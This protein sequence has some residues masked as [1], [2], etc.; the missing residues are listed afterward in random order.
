MKAL[1]LAA[2]RG[3]RISRYLAGNPKCTVDLG[4]TSLIEYTVNMLQKNGIHNI[5]IA[6]GYRQQ[7]IRQKLSN[8]KVLYYYNP[9]FDVTN[10]ITSAWFAKDFLSADDDLIIMNGDVFLE[11]S[12]LTEMLKCKK[13]PVLFSD[14]TR[15]DEADYKLLYRNGILEGYGKELKGNEITGEYVGVAIIRMNFIP[16]FL[17]KMNEM[18]DNQQHSVWWENVLYDNSKKID[19]NVEDVGRRFWAEVD[20]IEDYERILDFRKNNKDIK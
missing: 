14:E 5:A 18:I 17:H 4:G 11:P 7:I 20:Y 13:S 2:G 8:Q 10:S 3:T 1:I 16:V 15:K 19:I 9:F 6:V 12:L